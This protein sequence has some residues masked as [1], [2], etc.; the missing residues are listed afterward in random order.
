MASVSQ[1]L[2]LLL[3]CSCHSLVA[4]AG[5]VH[6]IYKVLP[7]AGSQKAEAVCAEPQGTVYC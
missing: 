5:D 2:L 6:A 7:T 4:P 1:L 3:L